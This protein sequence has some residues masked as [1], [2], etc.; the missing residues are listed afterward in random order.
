[1]FC[2]NSVTWLYRVDE[3]FTWDSGLSIGADQ[4]FKDVAGVVRLVLHAGGRITVMAG[5]AWNGCSPKVCFCDVILGTP[6]GVVHVRTGRPKTYYASMVH[7]ALYQFLDA[8]SPISRAQAD[9][10]FLRLMAESDFLLRHVY[11]AAVRLGGRFVWGAKR[12]TRKWR[13]HRE[14]V[15]ELIGTAGAVRETV[16]VRHN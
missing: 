13:G 10:C 7:D 14:L 12:A 8:D 9:A 16:G 6:D 5:Y 15:A 11:W 3:P 4:Y 2:K 1:M